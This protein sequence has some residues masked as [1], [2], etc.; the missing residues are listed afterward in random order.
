[1]RWLTDLIR[2]FFAPAIPE[3]IRDDFILMTAG[4]LQRQS[5]LLFIALLF[6]TPAAALAASPG[7]SAWIRYGSPIAMAAFCLLGIASLSRDL[8][9]TASVCRARKLIR[10]STVVSSL[11]AVMCSAWCVYSWLGAPPA[12]RIYYPVIVALGAFSTAYCLSCTRLAAINNIV[13]NLVP[14][15]VLLMTSGERMDLAV[16]TCLTIAAGFQLHMIV[17]HQDSI[18]SLLKL[19]RHTRKLAQTDPLTGL[20]NRRAL[21]EQALAAGQQEDLRLMLIDID[22]FKKINDSHGHDTGDQVLIEVA[23]LLA[24][25]VDLRGSVAR[26]GGEEFA[27]VGFAEDLPEALALGLLAD[28]RNQPMPHGG[29]V[30]ISIGLA[31]GSV[32]CEDDWRDLFNAADRALYIAKA[33]GRNRAVSAAAETGSANDFAVQ[34]A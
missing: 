17:R 22:H 16:G 18:V 28:L 2:N 23:A 3:Q 19:Q 7:A 26:I 10:E 25:Q 21:I 12:E 11:I 33:E 1:M 6:T 31:S 30:T 9:I 29:Q 27:I 4:Q 32:A 34:A 20:L 5:R 14:M 8:Q 13:I 15:T 24:M